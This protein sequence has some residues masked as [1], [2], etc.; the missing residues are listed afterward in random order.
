MRRLGPVLLIAAVLAATGFGAFTW[1]ARNPE[2]L[3]L[4]DLGRTA[5]EAYVFGY[6]LVL[7]DETRRAMLAAPDIESNRLH[8]RTDRPGFGDEAVVRPN[9]DTLYSLAWLDLSDGPALLDCPQDG[10]RYWLAQVMDMWTDV[11]GTAGPR[12]ACGAAGGVQIAPPGWDGP[13]LADY[14][15]IEVSTPHAWLLIRVGV[16]DRPAD[17]AAGQAFQEEFRLTAHAPDQAALEPPG[18]RPPDAVAALTPEEFFARLAALMALHPPRP[19]DAPMLSQLA[20]I[21]LEPGA[22]EPEGFGPLARMAIARGVDTARE[23]LSS[24]VQSRPYGPTNWRTA[25]DLGDYGTDYA[26]RAGVALIGLGAN[27]PEDAIYPSTD[28]DSEGRLLSGDHV[29]RLRFAPGETP[30]ARAFWSVT[31]YDADGFLQDVERHALGDRDR[32]VRDEDGGLTLTISAAR[33]EGVPH[34][35]WLPVAPEEPFQLTARLYDP[36]PP[37]LSGDWRMPSVER[38]D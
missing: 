34:G 19:A 29:Y 26:L 2:G 5:G 3:A 1:A 25:L 12:T 10:D 32:L 33:P 38:L 9:R 6:P 31:A 22:Y 30:P 17:L 28:M 7:M 27:R 15:R 37:A 8:P 21:G 36:A 16:A 13:R 20:G 4:R 23:R 14:P 24:G 11:A 35:N 18:Q